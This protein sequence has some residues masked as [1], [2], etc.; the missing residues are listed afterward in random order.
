MI[1]MYPSY[2]YLDPGTLELALEMARRLQRAAADVLRLADG[3]PAVAYNHLGGGGRAAAAAGAVVNWLGPHRNRFELLIADDVE[4]ARAAAGR[5]SDEAD[6]WA[7]FWATATDAR[8]GRIHDELMAE[9]AG[10][11]A[12]YGRELELYHSRAEVDPASAVAMTRPSP[13]R[14]PVRPP[15]VPLPTAHSRYRQTV[16]DH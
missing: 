15:P 14:P 13:P 3:G 12:A 9:H 5:L 2:S 6:A 8:N 1:D 16:L 4:M 11:L 7:R 10:R